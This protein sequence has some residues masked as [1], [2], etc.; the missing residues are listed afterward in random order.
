MDNMFTC[1]T[2]KREFSGAPTQKNACGS[3]CFTCVE[4]Q[5]ERRAET[6]I[7]NRPII[8]GIGYC[9]W[10]GEALTGENQHASQAR[11]EKFVCISCAKNRAWLLKCIRHSSTPA[12]YVT[13]VEIR[14]K[15]LRMNRRDIIIA[16]QNAA[17]IADK[18]DESG[19]LAKR[20]NMIEGMLFTLV[21]ELGGQVTQSTQ[22]DE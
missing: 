15:P 10:C 22:E 13:R 9:K 3:F 18:G 2:C 12:K 14:E 17:H 21:K 1:A 4:Q 6:T 20:M 7:R 19:N 5:K 16:E 11:A 8:N